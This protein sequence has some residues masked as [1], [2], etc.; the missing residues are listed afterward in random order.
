MN[1]PDEEQDDPLPSYVFQNFK[2]EPVKR[3]YA[4]CLV[5]IMCCG[6]A[7]AAGNPAQPAASKARPEADDKNKDK[8]KDKDKEKKDESK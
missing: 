8:N 3:I 7:F 1:P 6:L 2:E 5:M 4:V